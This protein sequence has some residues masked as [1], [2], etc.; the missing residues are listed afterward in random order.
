MDLQ[1]RGR[2]V[3][4]C[5]SELG[6]RGRT[7]ECRWPGAGAR[8]GDRVESPAR[9]GAGLP[10]SRRTVLVGRGRTGVRT[11]VRKGPRPHEERAAGVRS[12]MARAE[13]PVPLAKRS[14]W[15]WDESRRPLLRTAETVSV[16]TPS[17]GQGV[18]IE[19]TIRSV[20]LQGQHVEHIVVDGGSTDGTLD[21]L[22]HYDAHIRWISEPDAGQA[23]AINK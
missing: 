16:V 17:Y 5:R 23:D 18:F 15:P 4:R 21:V 10:C 12:V 7:G 6:D 19:E 22:R 11:D 14:G 2:P 3:V 8:R 13:L 1:R 20:L 9:D